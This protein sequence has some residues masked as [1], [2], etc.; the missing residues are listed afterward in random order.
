MRHTLF[1]QPKYLNRIRILVNK[2]TF[3]DHNMEN[4]WVPLQKDET[5]NSLVSAGGVVFI[6]LSLLLD[7][8]PP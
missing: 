1:L 6:P 8:Q 3:L 5:A 7:Q 4:N 2:D